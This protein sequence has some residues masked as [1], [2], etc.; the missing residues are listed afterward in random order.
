MINLVQNEF[1]KLIGKK[2]LI[3]V[4]LIMAV[5]I[6]MFT[7]AQFR[8][9]ER[10][11]KRLGTTDWR[12]TL[13][14]RIIES[15]N[16]LNGRQVSEEWRKQLQNR[17]VQQ[18][19][20]LDHGINPAEPGAP[21]FVRVFLENSIQLFLPLMMLVIAADLVS[22]EHGMGTVK[23]LLTRPVKRWRILLSKYI[24]L[25]L[26]VSVII[27]IFV[28]LS[29]LISGLVFGFRGWAAPV[30]TGF[31]FETGVLNTSG[32]HLI[33]QWQYRVGFSL[34]CFPCG[35]NFVIYAVCIDQKHG[36]RYGS[37]A[38]VPDLRSHF[39]Q[40][41]LF[42]GIRQVPLHGQLEINQL[43]G[44]YCPS[45]RRH[46]FGFFSHDIVYLGSGSIV[47]FLYALYQAGCILGNYSLNK[48][49]YG[50]SAKK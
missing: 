44:R 23:L 15:Q 42:L 46:V 11:R 19:Y 50:F 41:G 33:S 31:T 47:G 43:S 13:Q 40:Y 8:E 35:S 12:V 28:A 18:Q 21:T 26:S 37:D 3:V 34:V 25:V 29:C 22:S 6:S 36:G 38:G 24:T 9:A 49:K 2:R 32:V 4:T 17:V 20:Y 30:L 14:Q 45:Y 16:R 1:I 39:K 27:L 5:L 7:Y 10:A 48:Y